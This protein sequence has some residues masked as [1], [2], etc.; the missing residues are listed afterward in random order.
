MGWISLGDDIVGYEG[1]DHFGETLALNDDGTTLVS[2]ANW[3]T[4]E[5]VSAF[6]LVQ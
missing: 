5:Y 4:I 6:T 2:S 1:G 3:D